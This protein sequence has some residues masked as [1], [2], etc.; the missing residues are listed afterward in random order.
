MSPS[1]VEPPPRRCI[2]AT[3]E[4]LHAAAARE[5]WLF[6]FQVATTR[7]RK[8]RCLFMASSRAHNGALT[9][10]LLL[11]RIL[12]LQPCA[13]CSYPRHLKKSISHSHGWDANIG[14]CRITP[15]PIYLILIPVNSSVEPG[16]SALKIQAPARFVR[17]H[18]L[19]AG[20]H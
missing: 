10:G 11:H 12:P 16:K 13:T 7:T 5:M 4:A 1:D 6:S 14:D 8:G 2:A 20:D 15:R 18:I 17:R 19:T 3:I 9:R